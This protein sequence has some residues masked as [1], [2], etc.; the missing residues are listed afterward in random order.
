MPVPAEAS[1]A[2]TARRV[3]MLVGNADVL[4][5]SRGHDYEAAVAIAPQ[6]A[7]HFDEA[8][9]P[10]KAIPYLLAAGDALQ[11]ERRP[12]PGQLEVG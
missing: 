11:Q 2:P 1:R 6:L 3:R 9:M 5:E 12:G 10:E 7:R 4:P 8:R